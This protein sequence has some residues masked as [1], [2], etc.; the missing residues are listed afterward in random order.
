VFLTHGEEE[1]ALAL[2]AR[3]Q[4]ERGFTAHVPEPGEAVEL[5]AGAA[6]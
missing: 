1:A 6:A 5:G 4:K 2:A 3:L